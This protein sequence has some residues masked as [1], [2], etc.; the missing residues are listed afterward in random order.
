MTAVVQLQRCVL[1]KED[2]HEGTTTLEFVFGDVTVIV[3]DV[4]AMICG[5]CD[6]AYVNG[7]LGT[8]ISE[9]AAEL[10][11]AVSASVRERRGFGVTTVRTHVRDHNLLPNMAY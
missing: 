3:E 11:E 9:L 6:E 4:P 10:A 8:A 5:S 7:P 2:T 1:C